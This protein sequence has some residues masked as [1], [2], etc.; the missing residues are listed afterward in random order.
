LRLERR[1]DGLEHRRKLD[2]VGFEREQLD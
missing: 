2:V 1:H